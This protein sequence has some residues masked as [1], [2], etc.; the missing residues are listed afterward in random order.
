[1]DKQEV[2]KYLKENSKQRLFTIRTK[3]LLAE[4]LN[5]S[6]T[7]LNSRLKQLEEENKIKVEKKKQGLDII[8]NTEVDLQDFLNTNENIIESDS[9]YAKDLRSR[10]FYKKENKRTP[11]EQVIFNSIKDKERKVIQEMN[12]RMRDSRFPTKEVFEVSSDPEKHFKTYLLSKIYDKLCTIHLKVRKRKFKEQTEKAIENNESPEFISSLEAKTN[13]YA[14]QVVKYE[15]QQTLNDNFFG[16]TTYGYFLYL[17][18]LSY[19]IDI[20]KFMINVFSTHSFMFEQGK[21]DKPVPQ[22]VEFTEPR[23]IDNYY[24]YLDAIKNRMNSDNRQL[25]NY[26]QRMN[27]EVEYNEDTILQ[28][29]KLLLI[30][31]YH[32]LTYDINTV[33]NVA[34]D[35]EDYQMGL[36]EQKQQHLLNYYQTFKEEI[37]QFEQEDKEKIDR[38]VKL[39]IINS[40]APKTITNTYRLSMFPLQRMYLIDLILSDQSR[41]LSVEQLRKIGLIQPPN[42]NFVEIKGLTDTE[43]DIRLGADFINAY[44]DIIDYNTLRMFG[45]YTGLDIDMRDIKHILEKYNKKHLIP[46]T[47][48]GML[49]I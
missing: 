27:S 34:M 43:A 9:D 24:K 6:M 46:F 41:A 21:E 11:K 28:Q 19:D 3:K 23:K 33:F 29:L 1:M 14:E 39:L 35:L 7:I 16:S 49:N 38:F 44:N 48:Y 37:K 4:K 13:Y 12:F 2:L 45:Y 31:D 25:S 42:N 15:R 20:I 18:H 22:P 17:Y 36:I 10:V 32:H 5:I 47:K 26:T 30:K 8:I 40:Y